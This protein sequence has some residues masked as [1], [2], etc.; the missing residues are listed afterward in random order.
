MF[1]GRVLLAEDDAVNQRIASLFLRKHGVTVDVVGDGS[2]AIE[3]LREHPYDLVLMDRY[4]PVLDGLDA[5]RAIRAGGSRTPICALSA[6]D[7]ADERAAC[8]GAGMD[9][10]LAKPIDQAALRALLGRWLRSA[11]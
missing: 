1:V 10:F 5:T 11:A 3:R 4:M 6:G 8:L 2:A 9:D 7:G